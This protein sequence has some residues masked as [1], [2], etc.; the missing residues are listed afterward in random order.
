[1]SGTLAYIIIIVASTIGRGLYQVYKKKQATLEAE[2]LQREREQTILR[3]GRDPATEAK[4][5]GVSPQ[6]SPAR[7]REAEMTAQRQEAL[8][9]LRQQQAQAEADGASGNSGPVRRPLWP[10]GP[11]VE[12][13]G[14]APAGPASAPA[15]PAQ[16]EFRPPPRMAPAN[17]ASARPAP[18]RQAQPQQGRPSQKKRGGQAQPQPQVR[19]ESAVERERAV[20]RQSV[21]TVGEAFAAP[22]RPAFGLPSTRDQWR[23]ALLASEILGPPVALRAPGTHL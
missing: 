23:A 6:F 13:R 18:Q 1:M 12:V 15:R 10:G 4:R 21:S 14:P 16:P 20:A 7:Q 22:T 19:G 8:R 11:I 3:T 9:Q 2:R 5:G 17:P